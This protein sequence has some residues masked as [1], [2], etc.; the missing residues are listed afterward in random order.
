MKWYSLALLTIALG[1]AKIA[2]D[3]PA[4]STVPISGIL[5]N[6]EFP[7]RD[8]NGKLRFVVKGEEARPL[9]DKQFA[10][11]QVTA[12]VYAD[13][14]EIE[15]VFKTP[16]CLFNEKTKE[17]TTDQAVTVERQN[18]V[19]TGKGLEGS[20]ATG[21]TGLLI[22]ENVKVVINDLQKGVVVQKNDE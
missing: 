1:S 5:K 9:E 22:K 15:A 3:E 16:E 13:N 12:T 19:I 10:L 8:K 21:G 14:G 20:I 7:E 2:A 18:M 6:F 11:K 4:K 17:I